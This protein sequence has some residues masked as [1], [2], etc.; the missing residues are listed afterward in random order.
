MYEIDFFD[1]ELQSEFW[2][3]LGGLLRFISPFIMITV[4]II[5]AG[6]LISI[7]IKTIRKAI[8][9]DKDDASYHGDG[10]EDR[11]ERQKKYDY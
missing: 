1:A 3:M 2:A 6:W 9:R 5:L 11:E 8:N 7:V 4:A 10:R